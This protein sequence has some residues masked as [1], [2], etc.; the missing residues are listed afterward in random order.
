VKPASFGY[1]RAVSVLDAV[2]VLD[3]E[4]GEAR[5]L[6]GGQSLMPM[7]NMR[8]MR[9]STLVDINGLADEL[10]RIDTEGAETVVGAMVRYTT[11]E[12]SP[13]ASE[14]L[15]LL[16]HVAR[17]VGDRAVRNRGT[18]GGALAQADPT[19]EMALA[20][21]ALDAG[22]VARSTAGERVI[23]IADFFQGPYTSALKPDELLVAVRFP[24]APSRFC[25]FERNRKHNDWA[26]LSVVALGDVD[27]DR[28][29]TSVRIGLGGVNDRPVLAHAAAGRLEGR[30]WDG[31]TIEE[32]AELALEAIDPPDDIRATAE[33]RRHLVSVHVRRVLTHMAGSAAVG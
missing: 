26:V 22:V 21:L 16:G 7:L 13:V 15:P 3:E 5:V 20:C 12:S 25:F 33:Y 31:A 4:H 29:W 8:L 23:P 18:L 30:G 17:Y 2:Q 9:P 27:P 24:I 10:G 28:R 6:A 1:V 14:R 11:L 32:A 19:G